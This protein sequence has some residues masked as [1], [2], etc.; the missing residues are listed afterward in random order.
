MDGSKFDR[1]VR[2]LSASTT[3]RGIVRGVV[4]GLIGGAALNE[5]AGATTGRRSV[6]RNAGASCTRNAQCCSGNCET[7]RAVPRRDRF[8][9]ACEEGHTLCRTGCSDLQTDVKNCGGC[10]VVCEGSDTCVDGVC[11]PSGCLNFVENPDTDELVCGV[12]WDHREL[13]GCGWEYFAWE[14]EV[15]PCQTDADCQ[16]GADAATPVDCNDGDTICYCEIGYWDDEP[17]YGW[18]DNEPW[19]CGWIRK[20]NTCE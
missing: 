9:C 2:A 3:R 4:A 19:E 18:V 20:P 10:G 7:R 13:K 6:C 16:N 15:Y 1:F 17:P 12:T 14:G 8:R 11:V 5:S